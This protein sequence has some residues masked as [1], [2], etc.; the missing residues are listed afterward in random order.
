MT[1][2]LLKNKRELIKKIAAHCQKKGAKLTPIRAQILEL[3]LNYSSLVKAYD[4]LSDLRK[5][6]P[7][8]AAP[9]VYRALDFFV[10]MDVLHRAESL[11]AFVFCKDFYI[12]HCSVIV[13]CRKCGFVEELFAENII[14]QLNLFCAEHKFFLE[15]EPLVLNGVCSRCK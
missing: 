12:D 8:A 2:L 9:T 4:I 15:N 3:V 5:I 13:N 11:N 6:N 10:E 1:D 7:K 14:K